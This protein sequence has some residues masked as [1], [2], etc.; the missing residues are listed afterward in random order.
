MLFLP[1]AGYDDINGD[2]L[3]RDEFLRLGCSFDILFLTDETLSE[4]EIR[5]AILGADIIYVGGGNVRFMMDVWKKTGAVKYLREAYEA[6]T[7]MSGFSAGAVCWFK[8]GYDDCGENGSF[9][10]CDCLDILPFCCCPHFESDN[11]QSYAEAVK[12]RE[13]SGCAI[14]NGAALI[15]EDGVFSTMHGNSGGEVWFMDIE[16]GHCAEKVL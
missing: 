8:E 4:S 1:T 14:E 10:F 2:E 6:G 12:T 9:V 7:V 15:Y 13:V 5:S 16:N 3:I 11:W